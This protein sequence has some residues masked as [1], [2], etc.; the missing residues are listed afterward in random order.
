M[1]ADHLTSNRGCPPLNLCA[2]LC[3]L[4]VLI[5]AATMV[6]LGSQLLPITIITKKHV[7]TCE[8]KFTETQQSYHNVMS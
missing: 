4:E 7:R 8:L 2:F 1:V 6:S 5:V 3:L